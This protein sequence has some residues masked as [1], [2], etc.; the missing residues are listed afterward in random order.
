MACLCFWIFCWYRDFRH[1]TESDLF[2]FP[3]I[4]RPS[5]STTDQHLHQAERS[6]KRHTNSI[7]NKCYIYQK[8]TVASTMDRLCSVHLNASSAT[9]RITKVVPTNNQ[10]RSQIKTLSPPR[11][12]GQGDRARHIVQ[13][14]LLVG[15]SK[16]SETT[17]ISLWI[18]D[19]TIWNL[20]RVLIIS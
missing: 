19:R 10:K 5:I 14:D 2:L 7:C 13:T 9:G 20:Y 17:R 8:Y 15:G 6:L 16:S 4:N 12:F 18:Y 1:K 11:R 3:F